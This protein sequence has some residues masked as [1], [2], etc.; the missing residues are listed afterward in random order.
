MNKG[1]KRH[2]HDL[3]RM[4]DFVE[5]EEESTDEEG[6]SDGVADFCC[7]PSCETRRAVSNLFEQ[8]RGGEIRVIQAN[9]HRSVPVLHPWGY[10]NGHR[11]KLQTRRGRS[12]WASGRRPSLECEESPSV[13]G[14]GAEPTFEETGACVDCG[15]GGEGSRNSFLYRTTVDV[16]QIPMLIESP[17]IIPRPHLRRLLPGQSPRQT[18]PRPHFTI[19]HSSTNTVHLHYER[20]NFKLRLRLYAA[21]MRVTC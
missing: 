18:M 11:P 5:T 20:E 6:G 1:R 3:V 4:A 19:A 10:P 15:W 8:C 9:D 21:L 13:D 7:L 16:V 14:P 17:D 2:A 12:P